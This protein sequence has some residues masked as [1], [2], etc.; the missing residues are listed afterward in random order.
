MMM[1]MLMMGSYDD[2]G[3]G[4]RVIIYCPTPNETVG[5][6]DKEEVVVGCICCELCR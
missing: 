2:G 5:E 6:L 3:N 4:T 1:M